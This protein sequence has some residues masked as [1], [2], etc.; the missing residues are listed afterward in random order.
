[1]ALEVDT[2]SQPSAGAA[3]APDH[4]PLANY[5]LLAGVFN[6][7][8]AAALVKADRDGK[9][10]DRI[11]PQ[12][13]VIIGVATHKLSRL[14]TKDSVTGFVRAPFTRYQRHSGKGEVEEKARGR[15]IRR[16][17]GELL[18]CPYCMGQW[19]SGAFTAGMLL[20]PRHTRVVGSM[21]TALAISDALQMAY[22]AGKHSTEY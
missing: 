17:I 15:G 18:I 8:F 7:A 3:P 9:I 22:V 21:F 4:R 1:V 6:A 20:A 12:D 14:I 16:A 13:I 11:A 10:P 2:T 19:V 5:A